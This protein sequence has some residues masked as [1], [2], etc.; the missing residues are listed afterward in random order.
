MKIRWANDHFG[1]FDYFFCRNY[2]ST[3]REK[4]VNFLLQ[5]I[6]YL[7]SEIS[8]SHANFSRQYVTDCVTRVSKGSSV[9]EIQTV[10]FSMLGDILSKMGS[11]ISHDS[12][13]SLIEVL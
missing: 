5:I 4:L 9:W 1:Q 6:S 3:D 10:V 7:H 2:A 13:L 8:S 11:S 12:W